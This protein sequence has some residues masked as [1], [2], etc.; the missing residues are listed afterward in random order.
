M[1]VAAKNVP[2]TLQPQENISILLVSP[3]A[4][5]EAD[6]RAMLGANGAAIHRHATVSDASER[7]DEV[8]VVVCERDLPDGTWQDLL[9]LCTA[10]SDPPLMTVIS[11]CADESLWAEV[12]NAGGYDVLL[13]PFD[14]NEVT[15]VIGTCGQIGQ[16]THEPAE[17][18]PPRDAS[19]TA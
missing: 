16:A 10:C 14:R 7:L 17:A 19:S 13:K 5:D 2:A 18:V 12:L 6:L 3:H 8:A 15:R 1:S 11:R 4:S 9:A